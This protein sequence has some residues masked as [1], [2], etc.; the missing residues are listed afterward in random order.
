[1]LLKYLTKSLK[2]V[3][4]F[5]YNERVFIQLNNK[6]V[7]MSLD[8]TSYKES[9]KLFNAIKNNDVSTVK[10]VLEIGKADLYYQFEQGLILHYA[11]QEGNYEIVKLLLIYGVDPNQGQF[12]PSPLSS[13][14]YSALDLAMGAVKSIPVQMD[15]AMLM[16]EQG[17]AYNGVARH[18][19]SLDQQKELAQCRKK[20][21][22]AGREILNELTDNKKGIFADKLIKKNLT[23]EEFAEKYGVDQNHC[24]KEYFSYLYNTNLSEAHSERP[25][26]SPIGIEYAIN[27]K[28]NLIDKKLSKKSFFDKI[29]NVIDKVVDTIKFCAGY[30]KYHESREVKEIHSIYKSI[31]NL[32]SLDKEFEKDIQSKY[33]NQKSV[34]N[35][36]ELNTFI[37]AVEEGDYN[38]FLLL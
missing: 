14:S 13:K 2:Y 35:S 28:L 32:R 30:S 16:V 33:I 11:L 31:E 20:Y 23:M 19:L 25:S 1:M 12:Q 15:A 7:V 37:G 38:E 24:V 8:F 3:N 17:F 27:H 6:G 10:K 34:R 29:L 26:Y 22:A 4:I 9:K 21:L 5:K 36:C 18:A